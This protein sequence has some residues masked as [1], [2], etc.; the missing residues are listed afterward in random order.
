NPG[1]RTLQAKTEYD[2]FFT[3]CAFPQDLLLV[4]AV[5]NLRDICRTS[6]CLLDELWVKDIFQHRYFL[7]V[8]AKFDVI[9]LY[10]SQTVNPLNERIGRRCFFLPLSVDASDCC[11]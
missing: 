3:I 7:R 11:P 10:Y 9:M 4:N 2:I 5:T 1:I 6:V 8:L